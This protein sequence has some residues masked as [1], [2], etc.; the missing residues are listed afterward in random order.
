MEFSCF[1]RKTARWRRACSSRAIVA[2]LPSVRSEGTV[3]LSMSQNYSGRRATLFN[4]KLT[5]S[6]TCAE[7]GFRSS[8]VSAAL[9]LPMALLAH[10]L[11]SQ[12][13][14]GRR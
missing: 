14:A 2:V 13:C 12:R 11:P 10:P 7:A 6:F 4:C 9:R 8:E 3:S 5:E 1:D